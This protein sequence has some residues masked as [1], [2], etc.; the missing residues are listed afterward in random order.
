MKSLKLFGAAASLLLLAGCGAWDVEALRGTTTTAAG[1]PFTQS[2]AKEYRSL[3]LFEADQMKDWP[4]AYTFAAKGLAAAR[5]DNV[6]PETTD[7]W[8]LPAAKKGELDGARA[9]LLTALDGGART[10]APAIAAKAQVAYDCWVEQEEEAWQTPDIASCKA[11][12]EAAMAALNPPAVAAPA[13]SVVSPATAPQFIVYFA[14]DS[15]RIDRAGLDV[16]DR[17][18][19]EAKR[20]GTSRI[21]IVGHADR[22][23]SADY[24][25]R[26]SLRRSDAVRAELAKRGIATERTSVTALGEEEPAVPTA[27]GVREPRNRRVVITIR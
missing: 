15:S 21:T 22:S 18:A 14:W 9:R 27:D 11:G 26:L 25:V 17:A 4:D 19:A 5:G 10:R 3:T 12:F 20:N 2:L 6:L 7:R 13:P 8:S 23:G 16:I 1:T 24:N